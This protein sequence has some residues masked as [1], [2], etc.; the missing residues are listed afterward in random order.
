[1]V[2]HLLEE[3]ESA[4]SH[5]P[6]GSEAVQSEKSGRVNNSHREDVDGASVRTSFEGHW[7]Y[8]AHFYSG[9]VPP[10]P[11][12]QELGF[13]SSGDNLMGGRASFLDVDARDGHGSN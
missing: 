1:M 3:G 11:A 12:A 10:Q 13:D 6:S 9:E 7:L 4:L 8:S 2:H 5:E